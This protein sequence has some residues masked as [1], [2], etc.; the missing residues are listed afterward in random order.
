MRISTLLL[1]ENDICKCD[2]IFTQYNTYIPSYRHGRILSSKNKDARALTIFA[3][4]FMAYN[5]HLDTGT[6]YSDISITTGQFGKPV[7]CN[8]SNYHFSLSHSKNFIVFISSKSPIGIDTEQ[9]RTYN[10]KLAKRFFHNDEY[11]Y[12]ESLS[13][14]IKNTEFTKIWTMKEAYV[15]LTGTGLTTPLNSFSIFDTPDNYTFKD[16]NINN[17]ITSICTTENNSSPE[18]INLNT[19]M[20][21]ESF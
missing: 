2:E 16:Y 7:L 20:L 8:Y 6:D 1:S 12:L 4:L 3:G 15:K 5:I 13:N 11:I 19:T 9:L 17:Y 18:I 14:D 21:L 10:D